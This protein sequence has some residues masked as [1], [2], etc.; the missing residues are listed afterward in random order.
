[1]SETVTAPPV[2]SNVLVPLMSIGNGSVL[3]AVVIVCVFM[4]PNVIVLDPLVSVI[5]EAR[6]N[7]VP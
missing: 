5:P 1:V 6:V 4:P 7:N 3:P 2:M